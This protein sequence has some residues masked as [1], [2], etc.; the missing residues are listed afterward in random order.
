MRT[1]IAAA[2]ISV[3]VL[4]TAPVS[5]TAQGLASR[6]LDFDLD[7][8]K[9][10]PAETTPFPTIKGVTLVDQFDKALDRKELV[11]VFVF[12]RF[13]NSVAKQYL[14]TFTPN[15]HPEHHLTLYHFNPDPEEKQIR[16]SVVVANQFGQQHLKIESARILAVPTAKVPGEPQPDSEIPPVPDDL[17]HFKCY[18]ATGRAPDPGVV[19]LFDQFETHTLNHK[20]GEPL[21]FCNPAEKTDPAGNVFKIR[22]REDHLT[23]Y[24]ISILTEHDNPAWIYNQFFPD[25]TFLKEGVL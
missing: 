7:H 6:H 12:L 1:L 13:C 21:L 25:G 2:L 4:V 9:C 22:N 11:D 5:V 14:N 18:Y 24:R 17:D 19:G 20:L 3:V 16:G 15:E 8:F 10:Y 23:C